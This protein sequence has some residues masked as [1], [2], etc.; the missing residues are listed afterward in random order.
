MKIIFARL[1]SLC[2]LIGGIGLTFSGFQEYRHASEINRWRIV[3]GVTDG[4]QVSTGFFNASA[5]YKYSYSLA[6]KDYTGEFW[7]YG[8]EDIQALRDSH[9]NHPKI[10]VYYN[11]T[12]PSMSSLGPRTNFQRDYT[13]ATG[14]AL[15]IVGGGLFI[16]LNRFPK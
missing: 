3:E 6:G 9:P 15:S 8:E 1:I 7:I 5:H 2:L 10:N 14:L 12:D 13:L 11:P 16:Y 4:P